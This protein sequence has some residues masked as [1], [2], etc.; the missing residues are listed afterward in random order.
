MNMS[1]Y[2]AYQILRFYLQ[3]WQ[4]YRALKNTYYDVD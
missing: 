4:S 3:K 1:K 2:P